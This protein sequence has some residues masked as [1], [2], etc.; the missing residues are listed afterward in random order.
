MSDTH[1]GR[2]ILAA[3]PVWVGVPLPPPTSLAALPVLL[4]SFP[5]RRWKP[6]RE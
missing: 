4:P 6:G 2:K 1:D 5:D 3:A